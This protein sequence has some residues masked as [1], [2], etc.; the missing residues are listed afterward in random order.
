MNGEDLGCFHFGSEAVPMTWIEAQNYCMSKDSYLAEVENE[1]TRV[2]LSDEIK[3]QG[4][5]Y[6]HW[7]W[8][9]GTDALRVNILPKYLQNNY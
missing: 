8:I 7:W 4:N 6:S 3:R 5:N 1:Q 9:G 2:L